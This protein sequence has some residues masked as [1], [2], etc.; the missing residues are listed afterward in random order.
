MGDF[1]F[2]I[3]SSSDF[4]KKFVEDYEEF[5][6]NRTSSRLAINC[7]MTAW[8]LVDWTYKE[9]EALLKPQFSDFRSYQDGL[10]SLCPDLKIMQDITNGTKHFAITQYESPIKTTSLHDGDFDDSFSRDFNIAML[11]IEFQDGRTIYFEDVIDSVMSFWKQYL[12]TTFQII[13]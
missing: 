11:E 4:F 13:I 6:D 2:N 10:K 9:F 12:P 8:H 1:S 7:A 5:V 3:K